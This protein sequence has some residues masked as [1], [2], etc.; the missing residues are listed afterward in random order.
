MNRLRSFFHR[1][2]E[3]WSKERRERDLHDEMSMVLEMEIADRIASGMAPAKARR[4]ALMKL[5]M[6][7][8]KERYR[9]QRGLPKLETFLQDFRYGL[10]MMKRNPGFA[11]VALLTVALGIGANTAMFSAINSVLL[12]KP[13]FHDPDRLV[14]LWE[15][16]PSLEGFLAERLPV[17]LQSYL[18]WKQ[19]SH[20]FQDMSAAL[21][22]AVNLS[23]MDKPER[24]EH[25]AISSNFFSVLG[26]SP[27]I[28]RA[29]TPEE[30]TGSSARVAIIS[31]GTY[32]REFGG[33]KDI[34]ERHV[35]IN[36]VEHRIV[37]VLPR[38]FH[39][40][41][42]W[43]GFE[44]PKPEVW[45]PLNTSP[46]QPISESQQNILSVYARLKPGVALQQAR[47][48]MTLI[49]TQL[50]QQ[51]PKNYQNFGANVF[52]LYSEDVATDLRRSLLVLQLAVG[53][54]LLIAC[55]NVANLLLARA[56]GREREIALRLALGATR[57][58]LVRQ[59]LV[60]SLVLGGAGACAGLLLAWC[61]IYILPKLAPEDVHGL[62]EMSL[63]FR[64][65]AFT[66]LAAI[67][68][69]LLF[70]LAP[71]FHAARQKINSSLNPGM[72][73]DQGGM[74][75]RF[76]TG[77]VMVE[78]ALALVPLT[79]AGLM[80]RTLRALNALDLGI[81]PQNVIDG[82]V[83]LPAVQYKTAAQ[84]LAFCNQLLEKVSAL[85]EVESA[86][87]S[88]SP[89][90]ES[91][92]YVTFHLEGE[93]ADRTQAVDSQ[94]VSDGFFRTMGT[95]LL[96]GR[97]FTREEAEKGAKV[98]VITQSLAKSLWPGQDPI[99]K[100]MIFGDNRPVVI[101]V[102]PDRRILALGPEAQQNVYYPQRTL[103]TMVLIARARRNTAGLEKDLQQQLQS[104][105]KNLPIY[106]L[107]PLTQV[108]H[109][110]LAQQRFTMSLLMAFA[111]FAL[112]LAAVGLYGVLAYSVAQRTREIG[113]RMALGA[114]AHDVLRMVLRQ[115]LLAATVGIVVGVAGSMALTRAMASLLFG[116]R[117]YDPLTFAIAPLA[118]VCVALLA[119]YLPAR[120]AAKV[121]P[122]VALRYE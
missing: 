5:E 58:R 101:G 103:Q 49:E 63:D 50:V 55:V 116:V 38:S 111:G 61:G 83:A 64:V 21:L 100:V 34:L 104:L 3:L 15:K 44:Q 98:L 8:T 12:R 32:Q 89:P 28:G 112:V 84:V 52:T 16:N 48:E 23:G 75:R 72:R 119:S 79:G 73:G 99:G 31:Y 96:Q 78:I 54:V 53:F 45:T 97:D 120:R 82:G 122:M 68:A 65:L 109:D 106:D 39:L 13:P 51:F 113:I 27:A 41:A 14:M 105:D 24:V 19:Q 69:A 118:L 2:A 86:A 95:P 30:T 26:I 22:D 102:V 107:H 108:V 85:P 70:G 7:K 66:A 92:G 71:A 29:F 115:G 4:T 20:S 94:P 36:G 81:Q 62:H 47:T 10:R 60:E 59:V 87:L 67:G 93:T 42:M 35:I 33:A 37:G 90:M 114:R 17:R 117:A 74:S 11:A 1:F 46:N 56:A 91:V 76:R 25:G 88:G 40:T 9:D 6:Q 57:L 18:Y 121:D 110:S 80:I 43:A 77:L